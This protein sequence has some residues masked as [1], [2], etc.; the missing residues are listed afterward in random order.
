MIARSNILY[1]LAPV[2]QTVVAVTGLATALFCR[3]HCA[4][5]E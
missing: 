4:E 3:I 5:T 2:T 1:T